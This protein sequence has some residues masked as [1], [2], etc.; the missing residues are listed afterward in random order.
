MFGKEF[1]FVG[2]I[3]ELHPAEVVVRYQLERHHVYSMGETSKTEQEF[4]QYLQQIQPRYTFLTFDLVTHNCNHFADEVVG[5]LTDNRAR[6]P[7]HIRELSNIVRTS[8]SLLVGP[9]LS[10][11]PT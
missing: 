3:Q 6:I 1:F 5:W 2:G 7:E 9:F 4:R 8:R 11:A 10:A